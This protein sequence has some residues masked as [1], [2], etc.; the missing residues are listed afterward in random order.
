[1]G[2]PPTPL[3]LILLLSPLADFTASL[4][5]SSCSLRPSPKSKSTLRLRTALAQLSL[6]SRSKTRSSG[7]PESIS[8]SYRRPFSALLPT[9]YLRPSRELRRPRTFSCRRTPKGYSLPKPSHSASFSGAHRE[10]LRFENCSYSA[11][12]QPST[13]PSPAKSADYRTL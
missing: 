6:R 13:K 5:S 8:K 12:K 2:L 10:G 4:A 9:Y 1:M 7:Y 11:F 3:I